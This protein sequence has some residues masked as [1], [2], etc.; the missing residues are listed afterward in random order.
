MSRPRVPSL[1]RVGCPNGLWRVGYCSFRKRVLQRVGEEGLQDLRGRRCERVWMAAAPRHCR[2][3]CT[4]YPELRC[5]AI[6]LKDALAP[7]RMLNI[8]PP[9]IAARAR[10]EMVMKWW[11]WPSLSGG[12]PPDRRDGPSAR[13]YLSFGRGAAKGGRPRR[14]ST[15]WELVGREEYLCLGMRADGPSGARP[16]GLIIA[17]T[18]DEVCTRT[19]ASHLA[20]MAS[21]INVSSPCDCNTISYLTNIAFL[22]LQVRMRVVLQRPSQGASPPEGPRTQSTSLV[23]LVRR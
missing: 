17:R 5:S 9:A 8:T 1:G 4:S 3:L 18:R 11:W 10:M 16:P 21:Q 7:P 2:C 13:V 6:V 14:K 15:R 22:P 19:I 23:G 12:S 20:L